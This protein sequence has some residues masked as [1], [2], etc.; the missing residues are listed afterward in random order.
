MFQDFSPNQRVLIID[1]RPDFRQRMKRHLSESYDVDTAAGWSEGRK[2]LAD[3][4]P[5]IILLDYKLEDGY[6]GLD[7][8]KEVREER[9]D[10]VIIILVSA[11]L[12]RS[13]VEAAGELGVDAVIS[14]NKPER[15]FEEEITRAVEDNIAGR[16]REL[17]SRKKELSIVEPVFESEAMKN[18]RE[19][20]RRFMNNEE[21][22]LITGEHGSGKEVLAAFIHLR[23]F[24]AANPYSVI[25]LPRLTSELFNDEFFGHVR[26]AFTDA[27]EDKPGLL[28]LAHLGTLVLDEIG[29]LDINLQPKLLSIME[30]KPFSRVGGKRSITTNVRFIALTNRNLEEE[31]EKGRFK[32]DLYYRLKTFHIDVPPLRGRREDIPPL[33]ERILKRENHKRRIEVDS[34]D[35]ALLDLML[36]YPWPGNVRELE[37]WI[38]NGVTYA[39]SNV[40]RIEDVPQA[41]RASKP[42]ARAGTAG[43]IMANTYRSFKYESERLYLINLLESTSGKMSQAA[44]RAGVM[45][46]ALYRLCKNHDIDPADFREENE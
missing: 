26:G 44:R 12:D 30:H 21:N 13:V 36:E 27:R 11:Y 14:K 33:A 25:G 1:D 18:V 42:A 16:I 24:R 32:D 43:D 28:E 29:E 35:S 10:H 7:V 38:K 41:S 19:K 5:N 40:L 39:T 2:K 8:I 4:M 46:P 3:L 31:V 20:I 45:R 22:I 37:E 34:I 15:E 23:S 17:S 6:D 9:Y